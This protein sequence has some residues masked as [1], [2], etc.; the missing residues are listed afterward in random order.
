VHTSMTSSN[1]VLLDPCVLLNGFHYNT[2]VSLIRL[3]ST[4]VHLKN[5]LYASLAE[6]VKSAD[7]VDS[8]V[9]CGSG[10]KV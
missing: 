4:I 2:Y 10:S 7:S 6:A 3:N 9:P 5:L 1:E 8:V